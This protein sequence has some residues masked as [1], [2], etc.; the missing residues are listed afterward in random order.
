MKTARNF[1][2]HEN[3]GQEIS[4]EKDIKEEK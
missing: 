1:Y 4:L 3:V 2:C